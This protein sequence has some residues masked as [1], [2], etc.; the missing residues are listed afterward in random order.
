MVFS[1]DALLAVSNWVYELSMLLYFF[2][3]LIT[4]L[5]AE[6]RLPIR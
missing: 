4:I 3:P 5:Q 1:K 6:F 2:N